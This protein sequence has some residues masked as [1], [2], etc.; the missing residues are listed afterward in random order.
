MW[1]QNSKYLVRSVH[2]GGMQI[3]CTLYS[4]AAQ[5]DILIPSDSCHPHEYKMA[6]LTT[7][8]TEITRNQ[9]P[10]NNNNKKTLRGV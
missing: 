5:A 9:Y 1:F 8:R 4:K 6:I 7:Q 10:L 3:E 2:H